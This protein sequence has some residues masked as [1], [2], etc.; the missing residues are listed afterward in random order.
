[1]N[2]VHASER[3]RAYFW[4]CRFWSVNLKCKAAILIKTFENVSIRKWLLPIAVEKLSGFIHC[5][6]RRLIDVGGKHRI[7]WNEKCNPIATGN[8]QPCDWRFSSKS[9]SKH[10]FLWSQIHNTVVIS[11]SECLGQDLNDISWF[12]IPQINISFIM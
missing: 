11:I 9:K 10:V 6:K 5:M 3:R 4:K 1:M 7:Y 8:T 2:N 12:Y